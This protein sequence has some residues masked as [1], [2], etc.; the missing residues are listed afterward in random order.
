MKK[1]SLYLYLVLF[2]SPIHLN[3]KI[4]FCY[5]VSNNYEKQNIYMVTISCAY[6]HILITLA[7][8]Y[9]FPRGFPI[10]W[11]PSQKIKLFGYNFILKHQ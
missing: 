10:L 1:I 11:I 9:D 3:D 2:F 4:I 8:K 6:D 5:Q 7:K